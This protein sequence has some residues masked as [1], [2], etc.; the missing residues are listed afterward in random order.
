MEFFVLVWT[1]A[2]SRMLRSVASPVV[3]NLDLVFD[4]LERQGASAVIY[5]VLLRRYRWSLGHDADGEAFL[6]HAVRMQD[7]ICA[8]GELTPKTP[9]GINRERYGDYPLVPE[10]GAG[11]P[12]GTE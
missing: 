7:D 12:K 10:A 5:D 8:M 9:G 2:R 4:Y 1:N 6:R 11:G 3:E